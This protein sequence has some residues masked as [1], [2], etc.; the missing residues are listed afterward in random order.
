MKIE[1]KR[2]EKDIAADRN[3]DGSLIPGAVDR[4]NKTVTRILKNKFRIGLHAV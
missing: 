3:Q 2:S 1:V 4:K